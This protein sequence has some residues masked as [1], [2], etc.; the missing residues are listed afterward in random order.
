M[1]FLEKL[2]FSF[3]LLFSFYPCLALVVLPVLSLDAGSLSPFFIFCFIFFALIYPIIVIALLLSI[4]FK[5]FK[6]LYKVSI[7][8][9]YFYVF[10]SLSF[11]LFIFLRR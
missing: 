9:F 10:L 8:S 7:Y 1:N 3:I 11:L 4:W 2:L 5:S 6:K